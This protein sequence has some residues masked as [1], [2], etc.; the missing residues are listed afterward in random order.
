MARSFTKR[1]GAPY[2]IIEGCIECGICERVCPYG[3][4]FM[5][6]DFEFVVSG[7]LCPSCHRCY[8]PCPV[9][10]IVPMDDPRAAKIRA[11]NT[12]YVLNG[13]RELLDAQGGA[14]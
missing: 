12:P 2:V 3:A 4:I 11:S 7:D 10:T 14:R 8:E 13:W 9:D 1:H 5:S 6:D